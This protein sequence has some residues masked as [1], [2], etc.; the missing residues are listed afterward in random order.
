MVQRDALPVYKVGE[1]AYCERHR[2]AADFTADPRAGVHKHRL[3]QLD[4]E[5]RG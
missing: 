5:T 4:G 1:A 3:Y 2:G